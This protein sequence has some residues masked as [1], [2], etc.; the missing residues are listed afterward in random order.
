MANSTHYFV[1][2]IDVYQVNHS[3]NI[4]IHERAANLPTKIKVFF[5]GIITAGVVNDHD[6]ARELF[7]DNRRACPELLAILEEE[8]NVIVGGTCRNNRKRFPLKYDCLTLP[9]GCESET[10]KFLYNCCF[11]LVATQWKYPNTL[12]FIRSL[13][14]LEK[15]EVA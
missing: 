6:G 15:I 10:F 12:Q 9:M 11:C 7:L 2:N 8:L 14:K 1:R 4:D 3:V 13:S 5:N